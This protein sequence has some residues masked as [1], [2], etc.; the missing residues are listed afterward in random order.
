[1]LRKRI[2][3]IFAALAVIG[4]GVWGTS[5]A[6][7]PA[8]GK[9]FSPVAV[10]AYADT[11]SAIDTEMS[12]LMSELEQESAASPELALGGGAVIYAQES[13]AYQSI[14]DLGLPAV[15]PLY[16]KLSASAD[17]GLYEYILALAIQDITGEEFTYNSDYGWS[18]ALE[19]TM[20]YEAKVNN[21]QINVERILNSD[22][23]DAQKAVQLQVQGV[24]AVSP[25]L[26]Q[27]ATANPPLPSDQILQVINQITERG[28]NPLTQLRSVQDTA[29]I[30]ELRQIYE[31]LTQLSGGAYHLK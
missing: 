27:L 7:L 28:D 2:I 15:K 6:R 31:P 16:D 5:L 23:P 29:A 19:F 14:V 22:I 26:D 24:F 3:I 20:A 10:D 12:Q 18:N 1:M 4:I 8:Q 13:V 25:L 11:V 21:V 9:S 30:Q 17:S